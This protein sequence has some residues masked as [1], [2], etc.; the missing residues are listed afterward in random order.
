MV[1]DTHECELFQT[2]TNVLKKNGLKKNSKILQVNN[3]SKAL[4]N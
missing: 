4:L 3:A 1:K 2:P